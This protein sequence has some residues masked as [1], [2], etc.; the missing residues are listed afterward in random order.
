MTVQKVVGSETI[1]GRRY[2][3]FATGARASGAWVLV[4]PGS[5]EVEIG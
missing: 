1:G 5:I 2:A 3:T 4:R